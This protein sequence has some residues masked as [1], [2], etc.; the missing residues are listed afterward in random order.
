MDNKRR[1]VGVALTAIMVISVFV[2]LTVPVYAAEEDIPTLG[3]IQKAIDETGAKWT[4]GTTSV[5]E[6]SI[7]A[8]KMLCGAKI[9]PIPDG[10]IKIGL[11]PN[12]SMPFG[13][14][15]WR[16]VDGEN[17][18]TS[19]KN[20]RSCG[21]CWIFGSTGAF[22]AQINID[23]WDPTIDFDSSEQHIL[24][25][26]GG[27]DCDG[28]DPALALSYIRDSGVP[29][30]TCFPY[31][32][33]DTISCGDT[34]ADWENRACTFEWIGA[35]AYHTTGDYKWILE[36]YGPMVVV[37]NVSEDLFYYTGGIYEPAWTSEEFGWA[38][39][40]VALVGYNDTG[41][42]WIIKN[43][44]GPTWGEEG[45]G[46]V[47]YGDLEQY[48]YAFVTVNTT[49]PISPDIW[50]DPTSFD[51][52]LPPDTIYSTNLTIGDDGNGTL[53]FDITDTEG[54]G[55]TSAQEP[56]AKSEFS[57]ERLQEITKEVEGII[58]GDN[59]VQSLEVASGE[60][61][62]AYD[63]GEIDYAHWWS[64]PGGAFGVH[65]TSPT[66]NTVTT[67]R[68]YIYSNLTAFD[69]KVL[70]WPWS[71]PGSVIA[72]GTTTP[73]S[74]GWH[75]VDVGSISVPSEFVVAIYWK[76]ANQP[77]LGSDGDPPI[78]DRSW[79]FNG[80]TWSSENTVDYMIRA[81]MSTEEG[82]LSESP[83]SG[84][85]E[86]M[87][88]TNITVTFNTTGLSV[89]DYHA[90]ITITNNDPDENPII[91]PVN[92]T[93]EAPEE[94]AVFDTEEPE[95]PYPSISGI[96]NGTIAPNKTINVSKMYTYPCTGTGGHSKYVVFSNATTGVEIANGTWNGYSGDW[97]NITFGSPFVLE[98]GKTY[99]YTIITG[100]YPQIIHESPD[101]T[102]GTI[103]CDKFTDANGKEYSNWIPAIKLSP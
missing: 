42:Y 48:E 97:H 95:N 74:S 39:H 60:H 47:H 99:N 84:T 2:A 80:V 52:T 30:E 7:E 73:T 37:L 15:D 56:A 50:V 41:E 18:M 68:F 43:S 22:E 24:S 55:V 34:C 51:V 32:A 102:G 36:N 61:E 14:F 12:V 3:E 101:A 17:W 67:I 93:V 79:D 86:S 103:T 25:C 5:S 57:G 40:C 59:V 70:S 62:I 94:G 10:A 88:Q 46:R 6:L 92:L 82:W 54:G 31:Q 96:H 81:V 63:D 44:W 4:A 9:G 45:Y 77:T 65:F 83:T 26:S 27:G 91:I 71:Q 69:W 89:D 49:Y 28:G 16:N 75:D 90:N 98:A 23:A 72:S 29:D 58:D 8:K 64:G 66:Y 1:L 11:P 87:S 100:S 21:S 13:T 33:D 38:D 53:T 78:D 76:E 85:V 20:Q 35:P 19:V